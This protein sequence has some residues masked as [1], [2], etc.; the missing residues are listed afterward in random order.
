MKRDVY[1]HRERWLHWLSKANA[2]GITGISKKNSA[3][4]LQYLRDME[5]GVNVGAG[6]QKRPRTAARLNALRGRMVFFAHQ[7]QDRNDVDDLTTLTEEVIFRFFAD[8]HNGTIR[9]T[10]GTAYECVETQVKTFKAFWH[11]H[12][13]VNRKKGITIPDITAD[14]GSFSKKPKWVYLS[15][16]Q[17][18]QLCAT[19]R[20]DYRVLFSFLLDSGVRPA[21]ELLNIKISDLS[22]DC[23]TLNVRH[24]IVKPGSFGRRIKLMLCSDL[25]KQFI[26]VN[27]LTADDYLFDINPNTAN[28]YLKKLTTQLFG[29][30]VSEAGKNYSEIRLY[31]LRHISCCYWLPRYKSE[32]ALMYRFGWKKSSMVHYYT[33]LLGMRDTISDEDMLVDITKTELEQRICNLETANNML[34]DRLEG[35]ENAMTRIDELSKLVVSTLDRAEVHTPSPQN[36]G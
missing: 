8:V 22:S 23:K 5:L 1:K 26:Q 6:S 33:E 25:I 30:A 10:K 13:K 28:K 7:F 14:L 16:A 9:S 11:W 27:S 2:L 18:Q 19:A 29:N 31:D 15:E 35:M 3:T 36:S 21:A 4:I 17:A 32:S 24:E 20:F 12:Q 34:R